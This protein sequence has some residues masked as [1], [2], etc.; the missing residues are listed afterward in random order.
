[1]LSSGPNLRSSVLEAKQRLG[2]GREKLC[3]RHAEGSPSIQVCNAITDLIDQIVVDLYQTALVDLEEESEDGL[4]GHVALVAHGG[5]GRRD[6][7]PFSDVDLMILHSPAVAG[8][9]GPLAGRMLRDVGDS[10]LAVGH[11]VRTP[12]QAISLG[13]SDAAICTSLMESRLLAGNEPLFE[14]FLKKFRHRTRWRLGRLV[15]AI[16][17]A[18]YEERA[19]YGET[20]YLLEPNVKRSLGGLRDIH[21]LRWLG[22]ARHGNGDPERLRM[23]GGI[24][25]RDYERIRDAH[26]F[27][28]HLRNEMHFHAGRANDQLSRTEQLRIAKA[29]GVEGTS[30]LLPVERYMQ[31]YFRHTRAVAQIVAQFH[32]SIRPGQWRRRLIGGLLSHQVEGDFVVAGYDIRA[33]KRGLKKVTRD[34][35]EVLRLADL[36]NLYDKGIDLATSEAIRQASADI[37]DRVTPEVSRRFLSLLDHPARLGKLLRELHDMEVLEK[38]VP[39]FAH[40]RGMMQFNEY[41]K[42]T[43]DEHSILAVEKATEFASHP[44]I[45][46]RIY[47]QVKK[48]W[49]LHLALLLHDLGKGCEEDHSEVGARLAEE[50]AV[51][52]G[53]TAVDREILVFLV[54]KHLH[55]THLAFRRDTTDNELLVRFAVEVGSPEVLQM[56]YLLSIADISAVGPGVFNEWKGRLLFELYVGAMAH[57]TADR[58]G[59]DTPDDLEEQ[60]QSVRACLEAEW[61]GWYQQ[62]V[63]TLPASYLYSATPEQIADQL[64]KLHDLR[65]G[66]VVA[67]GRFLEDREAVE[68]MVATRESITPGV[69]H[70]L[71]GALSSKGLEILSAEINT[72]TNG[73]VLDRFWVHDGDFAGPPPPDRIESVSRALVDALSSDNPP[74]LHQARRYGKHRARP[75]LTQLPTRVRVDSSTSDHCNIIEIFAADRPGLLYVIG[76]VLFEMELSVS[77]AKIGTYLDQVV[78]VFYVT[79][80]EGSKLE[81]RERLNQIRDRLMQTIEEF[82]REFLEQENAMKI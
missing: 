56:L 7:A 66:E 27:L 64:R 13:L 6:M 14:S 58:G 71:A 21:L 24:S 59:L 81:D 32:K 4:A 74:P 51:R 41:H 73:L 39:A 38:I 26:E 20:V 8:R 79:D 11:S 31:E 22:F 76:R 45:L 28:L 36:A 17:E 78:D 49:L 67:L 37:S 61:D 55:M 62:E 80:R 82:E 42:F 9:I 72:L 75:E 40:A 15:R 65:P 77:L 46:S 34:L 53:L 43:I 52:L 2:E 16:D 1:M 33:T 35:S 3:Q 54:H 63:E 47:G 19:Q 30:G 18:R 23:S 50:M 44:G 25:Q 29:F 12:A 57:L 70:K 48:K 10:G 60:R 5:Y 69:F 68:F